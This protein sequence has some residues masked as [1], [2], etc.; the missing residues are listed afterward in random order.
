M[1]YLLDTD[2]YLFAINSEA[3]EEFFAQRF[4]PLIFRTYLAS[5]VIEELYAGAL[6][7]QAVRLVERYVRA[8][9]RTGRIVAPTFRDWKE[10][11]KL[12][13]H[14]TRKEPGRKPKV[15]QMLNDILITLC[16]RQIGATV[17][18]FNHEDFVLIRRYKPFSLEALTRPKG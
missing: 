9:E 14:L 8:L 5:I 16:A 7:A 18:T 12:V 17:F 2:V 4:F 13:A 15:Q 11:G 1:K 10:A 3:G 6:D